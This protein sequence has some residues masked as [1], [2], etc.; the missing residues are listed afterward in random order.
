M[1]NLTTRKIVL[2][3]LMTLVLAFSVQGTA[4]ALSSLTKVANTDVQRIL[5][6]A[7]HTFTFS[8]A[9][10]QMYVA[11]NPATMDADEYKVGDVI[12]VTAAGGYIISG[13]AKTYPSLTTSITLK[14]QG[15]F[16]AQEIII[17]TEAVLSISTSL[18]CRPSGAGELTLTVT[19]TN[20]PS[21]LQAALTFKAYAVRPD[22]EVQNLQIAESSSTQSPSFRYTDT[23][24]TM[25]VVLS[26]SNGSWAQ[27]EFSS[28]PMAALT[29]DWNDDGT[30]DA[31]ASSS[32]DS[33]RLTTFT[34]SNSTATVRIP[35]GDATTTVTAT[36]HYTSE[37]Y[38][39]VYVFRRITL[40]GKPSSA[41]DTGSRTTEMAAVNGKIELTVTAQDGAKSPKPIEGIEI[42]FDVLGS[43]GSLKHSDVGIYD[44]NFETNG[45]VKTAVVSGEAKVTLV[46]GSDPGIYTVRATAARAGDPIEFSVKGIGLTGDDQQA[47]SV[48]IDDGDGQSAGL[49]QALAKPLVVIVRNLGGVVLSNTAV[50]FTTD[51]GALSDPHPGDPGKITVKDVTRPTPGHRGRTVYTD[52]DGK[53]S[54]RYNVGDVPGGKNIYAT[55][56][57]YDGQT[58]R[59]TFGINGAPSTGRPPTSTNTITISPSSTTGEPG[60]EVTIRVTSSPS[61]VFATLG[62]NDFGAT[63]FSPQSDVT[64]FTS[65][66]LLPVEEGTHSFFATGGVLTAGRASVTVEAELGTNFRLRQSV[67]R[68]P[69]C[70]PLAL[71]P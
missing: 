6:G 2:G 58:R 35:M 36:I 3:M 54:V 1:N 63:R 50:T 27:V 5:P 7:S 17:S 60:E 67:P 71:A 49:D 52:T 68:T 70:K 48:R 25:Q 26:G 53:A 62:S 21:P 39:V 14:T 11:D 41:V 12:T 29:A 55:I 22:S 15:E 51:S 34:G 31:T 10:I 9:D 19:H 59:A 16:D 32:G 28:S 18:V 40:T 66:L 56:N 8:G 65:T 61:G 64:P 33:S 23:D 57:A 43:S 42:T 44:Q 24:S 20:G 13:A 37:S 46:L 38:K 45:K 69:D 47:A 30:A 4:D